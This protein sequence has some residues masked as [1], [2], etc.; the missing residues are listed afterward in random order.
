MTLII[1]LAII[2]AYIEAGA[3]YWIT[4]AIHILLYMAKA[5]IEAAKEVL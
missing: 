5:I 4:Y 2:G 3:W 1:L